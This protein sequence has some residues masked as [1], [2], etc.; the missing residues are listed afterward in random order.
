MF[1]GFFAAKTHNIIPAENCAIQNEQFAPILRFVCEFAQN[2]GWSIYDE[3][4][5]NGLLRHVYIRIGEATDE[6]M[7]CL[8]INGISV[9]NEAKFVEEAKSRFQNIVSIIVNTNEKSTNVVLGDEY[10]TVYGKDGIEDVLCGLRFFIT[11]ASFYQV[12]REGAELL[13]RKAAEMAEL[14]GDEVAMDHYCGTGTI[15]L[16]MA[17]K[18]SKLCGVEIVKS[19][20]E[21]ARENAERNGIKNASFVCADAGDA[22]TILD[23]LGGERPDVVIMDPPRKGSTKELV[24]CLAS[25]DVP[26]VVYISCDPDTLAR[27][28][29]WFRENGYKMSAVQP[30]DMFP[31]TGH[32]ESVVCLTRTFDN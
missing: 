6:I 21:C 23:A 22:Q 28:A 18:V 13:Y 5:G 24:D 17:D 9:P 7:I 15:G 8:V 11:P 10:R 27:D 31:R 16:S 29:A 32:V 1:A 26:K 20:V 4:S 25:L 19:A 3:Q 14:R 12:N 2:N 30:V